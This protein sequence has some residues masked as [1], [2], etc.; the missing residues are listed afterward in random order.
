V[1]ITGTLAFQGKQSTA[2]ELERALIT[3]ASTKSRLQSKYAAASRK[4]EE[5]AA[6]HKLLADALIGD[7]KLKAHLASCSSRGDLGNA[8][9]KTIEER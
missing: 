9:G 6:R 5:I 8:T 7:K 3:V 2:K 1:A 4:D